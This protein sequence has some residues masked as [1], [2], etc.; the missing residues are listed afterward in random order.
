MACCARC[1]AA[2]KK[3]DG[4]VAERDLRRYQPAWFLQSL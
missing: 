3:F 2:E 4:K 1:C